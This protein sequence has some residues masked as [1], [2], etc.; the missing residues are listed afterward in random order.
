ME[1]INSDA[2]KKTSPL[3]KTGWNISMTSINS[4]FCFHTRRMVAW[5]G[6]NPG[7]LLHKLFHICCMDSAEVNAGC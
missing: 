4:H 5:S 6:A 7:V 3:D 1:H 2:V